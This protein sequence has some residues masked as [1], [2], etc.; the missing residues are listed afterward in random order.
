M[1]NSNKESA[2]TRPE[3]FS[4]VALGHMEDPRNVGSIDHP[5]GGAVIT[6]SCGDTM[7]FWLTV[8]GDC[9]RD[10]KFWTDG[11]DTTIAAGS[12]TTVLAMGKS[13]EEAANINHEDIL[14]ALG[15]LPADSQHCALLASNT[16]KAA[17]DN[18]LSSRGRS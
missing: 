3:Q 4:E 8:K 17:I 10:I 18:Y 1:I 14:E 11:C 15:G 12:I 9:I 16:L 13:I 5:D 7:E 2:N 6:G